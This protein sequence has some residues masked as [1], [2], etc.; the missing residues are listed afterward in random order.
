MLGLVRL[1]GLCGVLVPEMNE[2]DTCPKKRS[3]RGR[4]GGAGYS[5]V[6]YLNHRNIG[7]APTSRRRRGAAA[8]A[9]HGRGLVTIDLRIP[10]T[11]VATVHVE[12]SS[13]W[14]DW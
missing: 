13:T 8:H 9:M 1:I 2:P 3:L 12:I 11:Y 4:G 14:T 7:N 5:F 6:F 10:T